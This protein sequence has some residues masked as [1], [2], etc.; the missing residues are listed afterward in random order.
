MEGL[1]LFLEETKEQ[2][3]KK[4]DHLEVRLHEEEKAK[5][6]EIEARKK[7]E[8]IAVRLKQDF[9]EVSEKYERSK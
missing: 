9:E 8:E 1:R 4:V 7:I 2:L 3:E 5:D 6:T